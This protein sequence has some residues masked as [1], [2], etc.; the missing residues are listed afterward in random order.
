V[1][2][3]TSPRNGNLQMPAPKPSTVRCQKPLCR[4]HNFNFRLRRAV[5]N[6]KMYNKNNQPLV[7][8]HHC[9]AGTISI[10]DCAV[11]SAAAADDDPAIS[12]SAA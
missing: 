2:V 8:R 12:L 4:R 11:P 9:A 10:L 6:L 5:G 7:E 1:P 3:L